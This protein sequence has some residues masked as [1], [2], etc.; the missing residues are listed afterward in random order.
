MNLTF[1]LHKSVDFIFHYL[2]DMDKFASV[3]PLITK[4]DKKGE[5]NFLVHETLKLGFFPYSF[6]YPVTIKSNSANKTVMIKATV[7]KMAHIEMHFTIRQEGELSVVEEI[8]TI[9]TN[10]PIKKIIKTLFMEQHA[11]LFK[12][13]NSL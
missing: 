5:G 12:N 7:M 1:T 4:I 6:T 13:I 2:T 10:L 11:Q 3:H 9:D 8:I